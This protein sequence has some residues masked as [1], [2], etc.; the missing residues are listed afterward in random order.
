[1]STTTK[2][3]VRKATKWHLF[4][5]RTRVHKI[6]LACWVPMLSLN[7]VPIDERNRF[8]VFDMQL[9]SVRINMRVA[10]NR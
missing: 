4:H 6:G 8:N 7:A 1:M 5:Y 9:L 3:T 10:Q 2:L